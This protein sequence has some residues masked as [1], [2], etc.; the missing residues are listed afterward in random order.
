[1]GVA[2]WRWLRHSR[3]VRR[4]RLGTEPASEIEK[5]PGRGGGGVQDSRQGVGPVYQRRYAVRI[6]GSPL[7]AAQLIERLGEDLNAA[8]PVEIAVFD[9]TSGTSHPLRPRD[10]YVVHMPGP[11][12][13]P[14]RVVEQTPVSFRFATLS[15]HMEAGEIEFRAEAREDDLVFTIES[16]ARSGDRFADLLYGKL[17][18]AKEMQLHMWAHFCTRVAELSGGRMVGDVEVRTERANASRDGRRLAA[19]ALTAAFTRTFTLAARM[20]ARGLRPAGLLQQVRGAAYAAVQHAHRR[21]GSAR[22]EPRRRPEKTA[23]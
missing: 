11:W 1:M 7:T 21:G 18:I 23:P 15:G 6:S 19:R 4:R 16:W 9:K 2:T 5:I 10:E 14:V 3:G 22:P 8:S 12:N 13:C 20:R 17:G